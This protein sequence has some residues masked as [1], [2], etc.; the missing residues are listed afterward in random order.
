MILTEL[1]LMEIR[2]QIETWQGSQVPQNAF[3][4]I[5]GKIETCLTTT[6][7]REKRDSDP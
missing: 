6:T 7:Q 1:C 2:D 4:Q 5:L 3:M